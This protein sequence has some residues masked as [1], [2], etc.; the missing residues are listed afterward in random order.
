MRSAVLT[1]GS[2]RSKVSSRAA[3]LSLLLLVCAAP[4]AAAATTS[5]V[6]WLVHD[7]ALIVRGTVVG[8]RT[9]PGARLANDII[10]VRVNETIKGEATD[11]VTFLTEVVNG[12][13]WDDGE[14]LFFLHPTS[15]HGPGRCLPI[16]KRRRTCSR[17]RVKN[18]SR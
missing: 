4:V 12:E 7:A 11:S 3:L 15:R 16:R 18:G 6:E 10:T 8:G 2:G 13:P 5:T 14:Y 9:L 1:R 17:G